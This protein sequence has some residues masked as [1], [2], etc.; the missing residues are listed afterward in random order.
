[1]GLLQSRPPP[2]PR[3][4]SARSALRWARCSPPAPK[5]PRVTPSSAVRRRRR[6]RGAAV[7]VVVVKVE[8]RRSRPHAKRRVAGRWRRRERRRERRRRCGALPACA[9]E[10]ARRRRTAVAA[11]DARVGSIRVAEQTLCTCGTAEK[12][13]VP[14]IRYPT[15]PAAT[16][17]SPPSAAS[18]RPCRSRPAH[19]RWK[20]E[21]AVPP[22]SRPTAFAGRRPVPARQ[23]RTLCGRRDQ[24]SRAT[25]S[26]WSAW[27]PDALAYS[28]QL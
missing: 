7:A 24:C 12:R 20:R 2:L 26:P 19:W 1:M 23:H 6:Q 17:P 22:W 5:A 28:M 13:L 18:A 10:A 21:P 15:H 14:L 4:P 3:T 16:A 8:G 11:L 27:L 9:Q 25:L